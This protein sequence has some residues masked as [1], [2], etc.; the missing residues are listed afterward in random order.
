MLGVDF[1]ESN[2]LIAKDQDEYH[3]LPAH[4][5]ADGLALTC[6]KCTWRDRLR[7]LLG[8]KVWMITL[9]FKKPFQPTIMLANKPDLPLG[10]LEH[11]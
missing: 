1:P 4:A 10:T 8:G 6:W 11:K 7:I 9:T 5:N 3:T 2:V